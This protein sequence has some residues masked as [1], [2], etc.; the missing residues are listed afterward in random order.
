[1]DENV[2]REQI[3]EI[4]RRMYERRMVASNDGNIS[5]RLGENEFLC[6]PTGISKGYMTPDCLC[7]TDSNGELIEKCVKYRPSS[8]MK[9]HMR[10][11]ALCPEVKAVVHAHPVFAT[12]FAAAGIPLDEPVISEAVVSLGEVPVA[13]YGT[14][15]TIEI[16]DSIEPFIRGHEALLLSNHGA[17]TWDEDLLTAYMKME[18]VEFYAEIMYRVKQIGGAKTIT[19]ENVDKLRRMHES[20]CSRDIKS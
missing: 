10:V 13:P 2:L 15:S 12:C 19:P 6:T 16:P 20:L 4:G 1:M 17:L 8:E 9:M 3:C 18:S 7:R 5:V 14:P 11:Y